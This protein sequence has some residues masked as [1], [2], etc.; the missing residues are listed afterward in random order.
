M[1]AVSLA[2]TSTIVTIVCHFSSTSK[3]EMAENRK[4]SAIAETKSV[5]DMRLAVCWLR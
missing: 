1:K 4:V 3:C 5:D 2:L